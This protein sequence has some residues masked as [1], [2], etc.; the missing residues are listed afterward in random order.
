MRDDR[1]WEYSFID[2]PVMS[3]LIKKA[4]EGW[5]VIEVQKNNSGYPR[6]M[7]RKE[8]RDLIQGGK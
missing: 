5:Q 3:E 8:I 4:D 6:L 1:K 7:F 2:N